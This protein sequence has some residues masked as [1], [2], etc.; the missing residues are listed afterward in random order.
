[1][2]FQV[3]G[4]IS[5]I[6]TTALINSMVGV[7]AIPKGMLEQDIDDAEEKVEAVAGLKNR[8]E[9]LDEAIEAIEDE[10]DFKVF[11]ANYSDTDAFEATVTGDAIAGVYDVEITNLARAELEVTQG[12]DDK[13]SLDIITE[14]TLQV[15]YAGTATD[16]TIDATNSSLSGVAAE[17]DQIAGLSAYV[18]DTGSA[19]EPYVLVVQGEDT[20]ADNTISFDTSGLVGAGEIPSFTENRA[21]QDA[22]VKING[23]SV[24]HDTNSISG[25]VPGLDVELF[26][27]TSASEQV[28]V[29]LDKEGIIAHVQSVLD[30]YEEVVSWVESKSSYNA[31]LEIKGPFVG[32][33]TVGRVMR[34]LQSVISAIYPTGTDLDSLAIMG[35]KTQASGALSI[36]ADIFDDALDDY[37]DDVVSMFT[38]GDGFGA[39]MKDQIDVYID[40][41]DGTLVSFKG[42]LEDRIDSLE[43]QVASY[44]YRIERYEKRLRSQFSAMESLLG[45]MQGTSNF[46]NA[47]LANDK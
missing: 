22:S 38:D 32:E 34:G 46:L 45:G 8:L 40:T 12:F 16:I 28:T 44:E 20:G 4:I 14:G 37:L 23:I 5:G 3:D 9:D 30:A 7:Y 2:G 39:A 27:T 41:V 18:L 15:S 11:K 1:M 24:T 10:S 19:T 13:S 26:Q 35:I 36:D 25:A 42:S 47:Y 33:T 43:D 31:D 17:I 21:A 29:G 6:D